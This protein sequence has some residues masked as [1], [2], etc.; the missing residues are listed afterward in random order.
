MAVNHFKQFE[1]VAQYEAYI[2]PDDYAKP[3]VAL[4]DET[5]TVMFPQGG[6]GGG[7]DCETLIGLIE[8]NILDLT[9]P[10][11]TS[12]IG[13]N[14]FYNYNNLMSVEIPDTVNTIGDYAFQSCSGLTSVTIGN[15][16]NEIGIRA[17]Y[18]CSGLTSVEIPD[19]VSLIGNNAFEGCNDLTS[20]TIGNGVIEIGDQAFY[21]C[22]SLES[23]TVNATTPP[24]LGIEAFLYTHL[25]AIY[26]P[27][28][29]V[30]DYKAASGWS[31][32][33][34]IIQAIP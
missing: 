2:Q 20:V 12:E 33:E 32:N 30:E 24:T 16:V 29:S 14:A 28:E 1:T 22:N 3:L 23:V 10:E 9:I 21:Q 15:G 31:D 5:D 13:A 19:S 7:G 27:A 26:V 17:F 6:G 8:R 25:Y 34:D 18:G 11:G 4:V